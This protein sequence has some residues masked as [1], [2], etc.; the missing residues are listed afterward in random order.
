[1][2]CG[3]TNGSAPANSK[4]LNMD[5]KAFKQCMDDVW[6]EMNSDKV[7]SDRAKAFIF[8]FLLAE[9]LSSHILLRYHDLIV[10]F[11]ENNLDK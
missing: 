2:D 8:Q 10:Q 7:Y 4:R 1:M 9:K 3:G 5:A 6:D 11:L